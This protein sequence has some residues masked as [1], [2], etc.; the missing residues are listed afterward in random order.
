MRPRIEVGPAGAL[1]P[2][3]A[4]AR[5]AWARHQRQDLAWAR[6]GEARH[7]LSPDLAGARRAWAR[8]RTTPDLAGAWPAVLT[9]L[10]TRSAAVRCQSKP[11]WSTRRQPAYEPGPS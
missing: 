6:R 7:L 5:P 1:P 3:L 11:A 9:T 4:E 8:R 10:T 2:G